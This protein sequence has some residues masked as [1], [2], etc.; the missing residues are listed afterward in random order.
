MGEQCIWN[1]HGKVMGHEIVIR[2][3]WRKHY[4]HLLNDEFDWTINSLNPL[5]SVEDPLLI[6]KCKVKEAVSMMKNGKSAG[7]YHWNNC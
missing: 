5:P 3:T 4:N 2:N 6:E 7:T 1:D